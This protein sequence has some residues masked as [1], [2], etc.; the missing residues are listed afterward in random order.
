MP[1]LILSALNIKERNHMGKAPDRSFDCFA[2]WLCYLGVQ[3]SQTLI[4]APD[5]PRLHT[6]GR[7]LDT[8]LSF[9]SGRKESVTERPNNSPAHWFTFWR[10][11]VIITPCLRH[12]THTAGRRLDQ[13]SGRYKGAPCLWKALSGTYNKFQSILLYICISGIYGCR[14]YSE[15]HYLVCV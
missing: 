13:A 2:S 1:L 11:Q 4:L 7:G 5:W 10:Q 8:P 6:E 12:L 15:P 3:S 14:G 9:P